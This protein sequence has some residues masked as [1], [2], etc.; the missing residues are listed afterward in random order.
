LQGKAEALP[1]LEVRDLKKTYYQGKIPVHAV[2]GI[3]FRVE[4]GAFVAITGPSGSGKST[5]LN[6][7]SSLDTPTSGEVVI[8]GQSIVEL[9]DAERT[10][11]RRRK[12]GFIFQF[13]N[14]LPTMTAADN[15][16][17]PLLLEGRRRKEAYDRAQRILD[18]VGLTARVQ[19]RPD[20][21]SGGIARA[22]VFD[23]VLILADEPTGNLDSKSGTQVMQMIASLSR[24]D[25]KTVVM[26]THDPSCWSYADR[27]IRIVDGEIDSIEDNQ[28]PHA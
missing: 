14:L 22:L 8:D 25:R 2:N 23:P 16:A 15:V 20:E 26:V 12:L 4:A 24:A 3:S 9:S 19:H 6:L 27:L 1:M 13:F 11:L 7:I 21:L 28:R 18:R 10:K 17:L 5:L